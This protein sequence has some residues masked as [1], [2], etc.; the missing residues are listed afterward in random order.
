MV[1]CCHSEERSDEESS[2]RF[3]ILRE[4]RLFS[5][6]TKN[7]F[8]LLIWILLPTSLRHAQ[9]KRRDQ[10]DRTLSIVI[11]K[12]ALK[13]LSCHSEEHGDEESS[14]RFVILRESRWFFGTNEESIL[15][16]DMDSSLD[17]TIH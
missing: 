12:S 11:L 2:L 9:G 1:Q 10:N 4:S 13:S 16:L 14:L 6:R 8:F 7:P 5:G 15:S 3:V 17:F